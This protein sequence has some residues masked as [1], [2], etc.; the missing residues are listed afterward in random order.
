MSPLAVT[1]MPPRG[2][3]LPVPVMAFSSSRVKPPKGTCQMIFPVL[4]S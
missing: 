4:R 2:Q 1:T 3:K